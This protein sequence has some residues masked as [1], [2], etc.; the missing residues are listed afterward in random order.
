MTDRM[1]SCAIAAIASRDPRPANRIE[2]AYALGHCSQVGFFLS[3]GRDDRFDLL[4]PPSALFCDL[5]VGLHVRFHSETMECFAHDRSRAIALPYDAAAARL[6]QGLED[7]V[8]NR[9]GIALLKIRLNADG[10]EHGHIVCEIT[11]CRQPRPHER[12][13]LHHVAASTLFPGCPLER[14][15]RM[16]A[17]AHPAVCVDPSPDVARAQSAADWRRK[18]WSRPP[19]LAGAR[20][21]PPI[22]ETLEKVVIVPLAEVVTIPAADG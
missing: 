8:V 19:P 7:G 17:T 6:V 22:R 16:I 21:S 10:W 9:D 2:L 15:R 14:E 5:A 1:R 11:D 3:T 13:H 20:A 18:A 12:R 4:T